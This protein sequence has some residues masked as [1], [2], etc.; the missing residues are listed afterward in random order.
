MT[1]FRPDIVIFSRSSRKCIMIAFTVPWEE[2]MEEAYERKM[3]KYNNLVEQCRA[4]GWKTWWIPIERGC[5]GYR[6]KLIVEDIDARDSRLRWTVFTEGCRGQSGDRING[7]LATTNR[8]FTRR[9]SGTESIANLI[10]GA[11]NGGENHP[12]NLALTKSHAG[13]R[14][15]CEDHP[16]SLVPTMN[17]TGGRNGGEK[18]PPQSGAHNESWQNESRQKYVRKAWKISSY[19]LGE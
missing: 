8:V 17:Q 19:P 7:D 14:N 11:L 4:K 12:H 2:W 16:H 1:N 10:V 13:R 15:V 3:L 18:T 5:R 9:N 6:G